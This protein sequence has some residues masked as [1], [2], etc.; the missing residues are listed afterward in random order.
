MA[1]DQERLEYLKRRRDKLRQE[2]KTANGSR[3]AAVE[4]A[5]VKVG[6]KIRS[7]SR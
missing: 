2:L 3:L 7:L 6:R 1:T 4:D 5:L